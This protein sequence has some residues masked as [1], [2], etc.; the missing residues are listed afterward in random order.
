MRGKRCI[1]VI[2]TKTKVTTTVTDK[3]ILAMNVTP[4]ALSIRMNVMLYGNARECS[5]KML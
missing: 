1:P 4:N 2:S 3:R 5:S